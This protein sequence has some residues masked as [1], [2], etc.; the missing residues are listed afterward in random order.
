MPGDDDDDIIIIKKSIVR[1]MLHE[2]HHGHPM[3]EEITEALENA[4]TVPPGGTESS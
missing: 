1:K 3:R 4:P 2:L